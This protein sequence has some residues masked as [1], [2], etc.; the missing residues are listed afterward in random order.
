MSSRYSTLWHTFT[1]YPLE[2][3]FCY[4]VEYGEPR[5]VRRGA[6]VYQLFVFD[7]ITLQAVRRGLAR[8]S[9][10]KRTDGRL[11]GL[12]T[13]QSQHNGKEGEVVTNVYETILRYHLAI[14]VN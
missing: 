13:G 11:H 4:K 7:R 3:P 8:Q 6:R 9:G 10:P 12:G 1:D 2:L 5:T 14:W